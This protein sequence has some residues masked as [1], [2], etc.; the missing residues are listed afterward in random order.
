FSLS[1]GQSTGSKCSLE[2]SLTNKTTYPVQYLKQCFK[3]FSQRAGE[4]VCFN[5]GGN[6]KSDQVKPS[7]SATAVSTFRRG[8]CD[9]ISGAEPHYLFEG[10]DP[11][12]V[13]LAGLAPYDARKLFHFSKAGLIAIGRPN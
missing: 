3:V 9:A 1:A 7:Q 5:F 13:N 12:D 6:N 8:A 4:T 2:A 10:R 11:S